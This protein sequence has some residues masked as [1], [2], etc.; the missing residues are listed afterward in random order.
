MYVDELHKF[1]PG[2]TVHRQN[3]VPHASLDFGGPRGHSLGPQVHVG[4]DEHLA[5]R[6]GLEDN[7]LSVSTGPPHRQGDDGNH[8]AGSVV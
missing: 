5:F 8:D 3:A 1:F 4:L 7:R 2:D 6:G